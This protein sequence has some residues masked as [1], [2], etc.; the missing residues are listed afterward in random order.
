MPLAPWRTLTGGHMAQKPAASWLDRERKTCLAVSGGQVYRIW[1]PCDVRDVR[2]KPRMG[3]TGEDRVQQEA[4]GVWGSRTRGG[5]ARTGCQ[6]NEYLLGEVDRLEI[7]ETS[8]A[9]H[10]LQCLGS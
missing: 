4:W 9:S 6:F 8:P 5:G 7:A 2:E 3:E 10:L 1:G